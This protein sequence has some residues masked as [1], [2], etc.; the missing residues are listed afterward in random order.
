[1]PR[2]PRVPVASR[3]RSLRTGISLALVSLV[4]IAGLAA[5]AAAE[6][7]RRRGCP[8]AV[9]P[10]SRREW[11]GIDPKALTGGSAVP[12]PIPR[13]LAQDRGRSG[14]RRARPGR[15]RAV[16][17]IRASKGGSRSG[18]SNSSTHKSGSRCTWR[19]A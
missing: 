17:I 11:C 16:Q 19:S 6:A 12:V 15:R 13:R 10:R 4:L 2:L 5:F 9:V 8:S 7:M 3:S 18:A 1:M 14:G